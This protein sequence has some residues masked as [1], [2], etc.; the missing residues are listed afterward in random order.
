MSCTKLVRFIREIAHFD[1]KV[2]IKFKKK[3]QITHPSV[4]VKNCQSNLNE[5]NVK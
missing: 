3:L 1:S 2:E 5:P 4:C